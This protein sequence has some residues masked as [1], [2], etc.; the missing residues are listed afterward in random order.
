METKNQALF[1]RNHKIADKFSPSE[2]IV[3]YPDDCLDLLKS[4][5]DET[6]QLIITFPHTTLAKSMKKNFILIYTY[7]NKPG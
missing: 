4:I 7:N 6:L 3:I 1:S 5:S 2:S